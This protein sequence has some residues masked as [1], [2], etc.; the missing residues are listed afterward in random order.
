[1]GYSNMLQELIDYCIALRGN[2][3]FWQICNISFNFMQETEVQ[4]VSVNNNE[5]IISMNQ[6]GAEFNLKLNE[7][8]D[9]IFDENEEGIELNILFKNDSKLIVSLLD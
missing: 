9:C 6:A 7:V 3:I 8:E 4:D 5:I 1:M 2:T